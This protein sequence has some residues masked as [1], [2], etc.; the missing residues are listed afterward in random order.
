MRYEKR[1]VD[2]QKGVTSFQGFVGW[3]GWQSGVNGMNVHP[4]MVINLITQKIVDNEVREAT[5]LRG[6][7]TE[8]GH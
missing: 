6:V 5:I 3:E 2:V 1:K 7:R 4:V 8:Y